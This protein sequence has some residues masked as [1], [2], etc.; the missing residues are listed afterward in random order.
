MATNLDNLSV[1]DLADELGALKADIADLETRERSIRDELVARG[2]PEAEGALFRV[3][4]SEAVRWT[5]DSKSVK[6]EMGDAWWTSRCRQA[7]VRTVAVKARG[8]AKRAA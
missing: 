4:V 6:A 7:V 8:A 2:I 3:T 1:G 5:I